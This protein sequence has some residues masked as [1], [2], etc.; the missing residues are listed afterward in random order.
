MKTQLKNLIKN[1]IPIFLMLI[2]TFVFG[3]GCNTSKPTPDP[4]AGFHFS[5]LINLQNN[6]AISDDYK[7]YIQK[8]SPKERERAGPIFYSED[9]AG[10]HAVEIKIGINGKNWH[11]IL[12]Y[13][14]D[15]K[16]IKTVKYA[17]GNYG[18]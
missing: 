4:L 10:Q 17:S 18:S 6:K 9:G 2:T 13:D 8:L 15:D 11:H 16:R 14:K 12:I 3:F 7:D 5:D 1:F